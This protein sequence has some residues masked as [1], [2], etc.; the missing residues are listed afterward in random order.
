MC[1]FPFNV[2]GVDAERTG[3][4][5]RACGNSYNI[6]RQACKLSMLALACHPFTSKG[7]VPNTMPLHSQNKQQQYSQHNSVIRKR[8]EISGT[9][10]F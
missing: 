4:K 9:D 6:P 1:I 8:N 3:Y 5:E 10:E 7:E 2:K